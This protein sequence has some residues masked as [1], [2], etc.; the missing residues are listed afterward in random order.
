MYSSAYERNMFFFLCW[1]FLIL[2]LSCAVSSKKD[3][4]D[5]GRRKVTEGGD[6]DEDNA[7]GRKRMCRVGVGAS[8]GEFYV[9]RRLNF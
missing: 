5:N 2:F 7:E 6:A 8:L 1:G 4:S 9:V 3:D